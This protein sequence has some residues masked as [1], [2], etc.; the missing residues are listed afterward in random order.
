[1]DWLSGLFKNIG[2]LFSGGGGAQ[3]A[4]ANQGGGNGL[5]GLFQNPVAQGVGLLGA[6]HL[7][8]G[9]AQAPDLNTNEFQAFKNF[10]ANPPGLPPEML[11]ELNK[12]IGLNEDQ[13][14]KNLRDV[15]KNVRPGTD[16][17]TDSAY[18][19]DLAGLQRNLASNRANALMGP[20][21]QY[22]QPKGQ[23]LASQAE[24]SMNQPLVKAGM[25]AQRSQG[26]RDLFGNVGSMFI[27][28]GLFPD[29]YSTNWMDKLFKGGK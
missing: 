17:T 15:Y 24:M 11:D 8:G 9:K 22:Q 5:M 1:M 2:N 18:Q 26:T 14:L 23:A 20:T 21:L 3:Q 7:L 27:Q 4:V 13:Q 19:R 25:D 12:S 29:A 28:K 6:G 10:S 16:Y